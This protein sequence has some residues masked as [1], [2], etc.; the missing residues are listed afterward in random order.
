MKHGEA[1]SIK[2]EMS[3]LARRRQSEHREIMSEVQLTMPNI[4]GKLEIS[5][6]GTE[7]A[8]LLKHAV[9]GKPRKDPDT[10]YMMN[11]SLGTTDVT[12]MAVKGHQ[13][14]VT[15]HTMVVF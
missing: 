15:Q 5:Q 6:V 12:R 11:H 3:S 14:G 9:T 4:D 8:P 2:A 1:E 10:G 13:V 7:L